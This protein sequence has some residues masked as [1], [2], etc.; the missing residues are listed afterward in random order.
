MEG[1]VIVAR[2]R[3]IHPGFFTNEILGGDLPPEVQLFFAGLWCYADREGRLEDRPKKLKLAIL[4]YRDFAASDA[5]KELE[6][7]GFICRYEVAGVRY[8]QILN[9][10]KYQRKIHPNEI[11][12]HIPPYVAEKDIQGTP[13]DIQGTPKEVSS[14][15]LSS[16]YLRSSCNLDSCSEE[17]GTASEPLPNASLIVL[18]FPTRGKP[19]SWHL[20]K[21]KVAEYEQSYPGLDVLGECRRARQWCIDNKEKQKTAK[22]MPG[23]LNRWLTTACDRPAKER[24][25]RPADS[26]PIE[27]PKRMPGT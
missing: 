18:D 20:T 9:W 1:A 4:P 22:G 23:F 19:K 11:Q 27:L 15:A 3:D 2:K 25:G 21:T 17:P 16:C 8:I 24:N 6:S 10:K 26:K 5:I 14:N 13:K 7:T 12:S